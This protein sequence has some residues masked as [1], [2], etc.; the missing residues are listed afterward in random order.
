MITTHINADFDAVASMLAAQKLYPGSIAVFPD[1]NKKTRNHFFIDSMAYLFNM[2]PP[3]DILNMNVELLVLV[4]VAKARRIGKMAALLENKEMQIHI[5]DHH[6]ESPNDIQ[7]DFSI[8][9]ATGAAVTI[10]VEIIK[11]K[12]I[13][14]TPDE[15]TLLGLGIYE[16]TGSFT[17]SS[18]TPDDLEAAA[19]LVSKG[20]RLD[21]ISDM[22]AGDINPRQITILNEL[23]EACVTH[24]INGVEV[25][26]ATIA[27]DYYIPDLAWMVQKIAKMESLKAF[28]AI[29]LMDNKIYVVGRSRMDEVDVAD[30]LSP[31]GG[32]GHPFAASASIKNKTLAQVEIELFEQLKKKAVALRVARRMM[33]SPAI[34]VESHLSCAEAGE[35]MTRYNINAALVVKKSE[36]PGDARHLLGLITRQVIG[37]ALFHQLGHARVSEYMSAECQTVGPDSGLLEIQDK[38]IDSNQRILP[39]VENNVILG[40]VTRTDL[41]KTLIKKPEFYDISETDPH[42]ESESV[43]SR[44][45]Q[46]LMKERLPKP[47]LEILRQIGETAQKGGYGAYLVGGFVRDL[48]LYRKNEDMDIVIEGDGIAFA[49]DYASLTGARVN[50]HTKFATAV[51]IFPDGLK[52][53]VASARLEFYKYPA[54]MP[55]VEMS[56]IKLD[57]FRRDFTIN[58]LAIKLNPDKFGVLIDFFSARKD[59]KRKAIR[60]LHNLSFVEDPTRVFRAIR[61]EQRFGF[62][63]GKLTSGLIKNAVDMDFF[64]RLSGKRFFNELRQILEEESPIPA[65]ARLADYGLLRVID[66]KVILNDALIS[67]F[68]SVEKALAWYELLFLEESYMKWVVY[69]I[70][71]TTGCDEKSSQAICR[72]YD[73]PASL[74]TIFYQ[75]RFKADRLLLRMRRG[76]APSNSEIYRRFSKFKTESLLYMMAAAKKEE[77]KRAISLYF[78]HLRY[79]KISVTGTDLKREGLAPGPEYTEILDKIRDA[80]LDKT[81]ASPKDEMDFAKR[82]VSLKLKQ[83]TPKEAKRPKETKR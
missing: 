72:R 67:M 81:I 12:E 73:I 43:P 69:F 21:V 5:Y 35:L 44:N 80:A 11:K 63:I 68:H 23:I 34:T 10:L 46:S 16:D 83:T 48:F 76:P 65:I 39:V 77:T 74:E 22:I 36:S 41:L 6:P 2:S 50:A 13:P 82:Q 19:F 8:R 26:V 59:I 57:L 54:A 7:P 4:D 42:K 20:A 37:K 61:F 29:A 56:S 58:T 66:E 33:S 78:T 3:K 27:T 31:M 64:K 55:T 51:I 49:R 15:A 28:F 38:I 52:I 62:K 32:G 14:I 60:A 9:R 79:V 24:I 18:T 40:V 71:L 1:S 75:E 53:D 17:F 70:V 47:T 30:I 25:V 45:I